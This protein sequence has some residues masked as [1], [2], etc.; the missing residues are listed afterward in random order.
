MEQ[1]QTEDATA[2]KA[3][4][5]RFKGMNKNAQTPIGDLSGTE[6]ELTVPTPEMVTARAREIALTNERKPNEFTQ[7]D[8]EQA[9]R[10]LTGVE[11][12]GAS[13]DAVKRGAVPGQTGGQA[14]RLEPK[15]EALLDERLAS[16]GVEEAA[17][18]QRVEA[19]KEDQSQEG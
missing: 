5:L 17:H 4:Q 3:S 12:S 2:R 7:E 11:T 15:D 10:E 16:R 9:R 8:W 6:T 18:D 1:I 13:D 14:P 19:A